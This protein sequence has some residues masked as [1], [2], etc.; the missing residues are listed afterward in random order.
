MNKHTLLGLINKAYQ[1]DGMMDKFEAFEI[2]NAITREAKFESSNIVGE[3]GEAYAHRYYGGTM[4]PPSNKHYDIEVDGKR[5]QVKT[6][7]EKTPSIDGIQYKDVFD[8]IAL[9][10]YN[11]YG[12]AG[13]AEISHD[14]FF[15]NAKYRQ[16]KA[17]PCYSWTLPKEVMRRDRVYV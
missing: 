4:M 16:D 12:F 11:E 2:I 10:F 14:E 3:A 1:D 6:R 17:K 5:I 15:E 7:I 8:M 13:I 9:V